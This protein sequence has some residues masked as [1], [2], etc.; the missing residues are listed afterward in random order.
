MYTLRHAYIEAQ[1]MIVR[2]LECGF[3]DESTD[4]ARYAI[5]TLGRLFDLL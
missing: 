3:N 5:I 2:L 4:C 1:E